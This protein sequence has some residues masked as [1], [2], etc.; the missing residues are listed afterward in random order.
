MLSFLPSKTPDG[1]IPPVFN[2]GLWS[3]IHGY[4]TFAD[5]LGYAQ[6]AVSNVWTASQTHTI[7][8]ENIPTEIF[9][10]CHDDYTYGPARFS[11]YMSFYM[12]INFSV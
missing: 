8:T 2:T 9:Q 7:T 10:S 11:F 5:L 3:F 6:M 1:S 4:V 12:L